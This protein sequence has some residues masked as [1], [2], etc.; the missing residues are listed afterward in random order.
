MTYFNEVGR[1]VAGEGM[2]LFGETPSHYYRLTQPE[3]TYDQILDRCKQFDAAP[4]SVT[5]GDFRRR[6]EALLDTLKVSPEYSNLLKGVH[7]PFAFQHTGSEVDLGS[8]LENTLLPNL[9]N[10]FNAR[11]PEAHFKAVLQSNSELPGHITLH[12]ASRYQQFIDASQSGTVV[13]WY[14]PQALQEF[15]VRSQRE[16]MT[17]LPELG[18]ANICLSG[19]MDICAALVGSPDLLIS[20]EF[21]TPILCLSAYVHA[22]PRLVLLLK[23]YGPHMEF[24]CMTNMLTKDTTQVSEQWTGGLTVFG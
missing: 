17:S 21:Y 11:Y 16:Q 6:A 12:P 7:V 22:D 19:G 13:G 3:L 15:D 9:Q 20:E 1:R 24:W 10:S 8:N 4:A 2:R 5:V 18:G 23:A 14:F